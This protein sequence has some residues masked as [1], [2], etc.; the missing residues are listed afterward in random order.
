M[1]IPQNKK[2]TLY[3]HGMHCKA[4]VVLTESELQDHPRVAAAVSNLEKRTVEVSGDFE[5][6]S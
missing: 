5:G 6:M 3:V 4:C 1:A 2:C